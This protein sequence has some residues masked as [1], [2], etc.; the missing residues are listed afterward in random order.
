[1]PGREAVEK[2]DLK[3]AV[4]VFAAFGALGGFLFKQWNKYKTKKIQF[5]K[6]IS[7]NLYFRNLVNNSGVFFSLIGS[8]EEEEC[9]EAFLA[10]CFLLT[11][12][13]GLTEQELDRKIE[14]WLKEEYGCTI[15]FEC[16][17]ALEKL[18]RLGILVRK[19]NNILKAARMDETLR[20]LDERWDNS[21]TYNF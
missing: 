21:F 16:S 6:E 19:D 14:T 7:D 11:E 13:Q 10:Y 20:I 8:A 15:D 4:A 12:G 1:M 18:D 5:Q 9:K 17:G 2:N 3:Q